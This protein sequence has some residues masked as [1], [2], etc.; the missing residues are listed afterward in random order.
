[1]QRRWYFGLPLFLGMLLM[2]ISS[3]LQ[4]WKHDGKIHG[5]KQGR[6]N[7]T[8]HS[9]SK[10][11]SSFTVRRGTE[12]RQVVYSPQTTITSMNRPSS[13]DE[14]KEGRRVICL[15]KINGRNELVASQ[16]DI[17]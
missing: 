16:I 7:A 17:R 6:L 1:M 11:T 5:P 10:E 13:V 14:I 2:P 4:A 8:V 12:D 15:G 3:P 9:L